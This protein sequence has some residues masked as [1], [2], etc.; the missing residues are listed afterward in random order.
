MMEVM[1]MGPA[2]YGPQF[3]GPGVGSIGG[4]V[5]E[6]SLG[7]GAFQRIAQQN[8]D[9]AQK[10]MV[11]DAATVYSEKQGEIG[12]YKLLVKNT[13]YRNKITDEIV[14]EKT[15]VSPDF[16][17][18]AAGVWTSA[19]EK[20]TVGT[21]E[22]Y[23]AT[24]NRARKLAQIDGDASMFWVSPSSEG[25]VHRAYLWVKTGEEVEAFQYIIPGKRQ[26]VSTMMRELGYQDTDSKPLEDQTIIRLGNEPKIHHKEVFEAVV[27]SLAPDEADQAKHIL[28]KFRQEAEI[29]DSLRKQR[30]KSYQGE[31]EAKLNNEKLKKVYENDIEKWLKSVAQGFAAL[32]RLDSNLDQNKMISD[33]G[34]KDDRNNI[35]YFDYLKSQQKD[36]QVD[37]Q[38][39][40]SAILQPVILSVLGFID[41]IA[42]NNK[43]LEERI[44]ASIEENVIVTADRYPTRKKL[45]KDR[46][47]TKREWV[48]G[49]S[50]SNDDS[51][52][53]HESFFIDEDSSPFT[54]E[55][56]FWQGVI[57][58]IFQ[59]ASPGNEDDQIFFARQVGIV[60]AEDNR[61]LFFAQR[62]FDEVL[63]ESV[64]VIFADEINEIPLA[65]N[66]EGLQSIINSF[67]QGLEVISNLIDNKFEKGLEQY[68]RGGE[69]HEQK[70]IETEV[71]KL[72]IELVQELTRDKS[73]FD[74]LKEGEYETKIDAL[75][76]LSF[77][78][79]V[80]EDTNTSE[81]IKQLII[82]LIFKQ[83]QVIQADKP[84][85]IEMVRGK[86][87]FSQ[88][89]KLEEIF[90]KF[91]RLSAYSDYLDGRFELLLLVLQKI[92]LENTF[93]RNKLE[94]AGEVNIGKLI[95]II[96]QM[97]QL[98]DFEEMYTNHKQ[99][100]FSIEKLQNK[101]NHGLR[102][103]I[104]NQFKSRKNNKKAANKFAPYGLIYQYSKGLFVPPGG[105][106]TALCGH[107]RQLINQMRPI[108]YK[109]VFM[110]E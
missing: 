43:K 27:S 7:R 72:G 9:A 75:A 80:Y 105:T 12:H 65:Q 52:K 79:Q 40:I 73:L 84:R 8:L 58:M 68:P 18:E 13:I 24:V 83:I 56:V 4:C 3:V 96:F 6:P 34:T 33:Q 61:E 93:T 82:T 67:Q 89:P 15:L 108:A 87:L 30:L 62:S 102:M 106:I 78:L 10:A 85:T 41:I 39:K 54:S 63:M 22:E 99:A 29:P 44:V 91:G 107:T 23:S 100:Q 92:Y 59:P 76:Q 32:S 77:L 19:G 60:S 26:A 55:Q 103:I 35:A 86:D 14:N 5:F 16:N 70:T 38:A 50:G 109:A 11:V 31:Y 37:E 88:N 81:L 64:P 90:K 94:I 49:V 47:I 104:F 1:Q 53:L 21:I 69:K 51:Y 20:N 95:F 28:N 97:A 74:R 46:L 42:G 98:T 45:T 25:D 17:Y 57:S 36:K 48:A 110:P 2:S 71:V 66:S 101:S